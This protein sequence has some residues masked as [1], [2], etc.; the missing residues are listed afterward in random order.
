MRQ[1]NP[2]P[3]SADIATL[4][5]YSEAINQ[6]AA[7]ELHPFVSVTTTY[8]AGA[9]DLVIYVVPAGAFT[10]T[11]PAPS[12]T[13]GR[14]LRVKRANNTTHVITITPASGLIDSAAN[15]TLTTAY[16]AKA[17]HSDGV[18]YWSM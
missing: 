6:A 17:F 5:E 14:I 15:T 9:A 10:V 4:R 16:Q 18:G 13:K 11:L 1:V 12:E 7:G 2:Y 8:S 3:R